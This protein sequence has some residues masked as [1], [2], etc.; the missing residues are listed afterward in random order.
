MRRL[1]RNYSLSAT[2][3]ALW[4]VFWVIHTISGWVEFV[5]EQG[6]HGATAELF[7]PDGYV[8]VW[9]KSTFENNQSEMLQLFTFVVLTTYL[10]HRNSPESRDSQERME[11]MLKRI[12]RKVGAQQS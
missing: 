6:E 7:G 9:L 5:A 11:Q 1:W 2:L 4:I 10:V 3:A 8:W 12:E